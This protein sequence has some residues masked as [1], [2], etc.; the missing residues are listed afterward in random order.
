MEFHRAVVL[1]LPRPNHP[2]HLRAGQH[3]AHQ[4]VSHASQN[5]QPLHHPPLVQ[6]ANRSRS[7]GYD[8]C[9]ATSCKNQKGDDETS[10]AAKKNLTKSSDIPNAAAHIP[11]TGSSQVAFHNPASH[12][13]YALSFFLGQFICIPVDIYFTI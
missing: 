12:S 13:V 9:R 2:S 11:V 5:Q 6:Q 1:G 3:A 4:M 8:D 10:H 7:V